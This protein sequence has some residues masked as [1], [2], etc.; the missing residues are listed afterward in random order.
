MELE[1]SQART[2][3]G[4]LKGRKGS[5]YNHSSLYTCMKLYHKL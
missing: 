5:Q 1:E 4:K 2:I 3:M